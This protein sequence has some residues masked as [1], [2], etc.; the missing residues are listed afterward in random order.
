MITVDERRCAYCG[1]CVSVCPASVL[2]LVE[3]RLHI[4]EGCTACGRCVRACPVG[5]LSLVGE[6]TKA[7]P[8]PS[9]TPR[10]CDVVVVGAGPAGATAARYAAQA[11]LS[12]LLVEKRQEIG[13]PVQ[14]AEG[15]AREQI[16]PFIEPDSR[17]ISAT[18]SQAQ[19][20]VVERGKVRE[21]AGGGALGYIL[22]RRIFD[23]ALAEQAVAAGA[24]LMV[25]TMAVGLLLEDNVVKGVELATPAGRQEVQARIVVAADGV[26]SWVGRWAGLETRLHPQDLM[27]CAQYL[28]AGIDIN[29]QCT[30][31]YLDETLA[32]GGYA[33]IFPKGEGRANVGL[34]IQ[35]DL[36]EMPPQAYLDRF[37]EYHRFLAQGSPVCLVAGGVPVSLPPSHIV[38]NGLM[39]IGDAARQVDP[40]TGGGIGNGMVAGRLAA[41]VAV[42]ALEAGD[43]SAR[44]LDRYRERWE[45]VLGRKMARNY[46]IRTRF[47]PGARKDERFLQVFALAI[48]GGK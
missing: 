3:T 23:R 13:T 27:S 20:A 26:E 6:T 24:R 17:W 43:T 12:V 35:S 15:V 11:G 5:T 19:I 40:L 31:Y 1:S 39:L 21:M 34:G 4:L 41:E 48:G 37:V 22:E 2:I 16:A 36:A 42:E 47:G 32:P 14:C 30:Y 38:T 46:R 9:R 29:P 44:F 28:L 45:S 8:L 7:S 25:K 18:I 33:W 10:A